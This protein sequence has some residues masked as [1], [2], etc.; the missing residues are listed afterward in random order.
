MARS[1]VVR[2]RLSPSVSRLAP[3]GAGMASAPS[4]PPG[5]GASGLAGPGEDG[6]GVAVGKSPSAERWTAAPGAVAISP[7][8]TTCEKNSR[9]L[10]P[11]PGDDSGEPPQEWATA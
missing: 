7:S 2:P 10:A 1:T 8:D 9:A 6:A 11:T 5:A 4:R 3:W